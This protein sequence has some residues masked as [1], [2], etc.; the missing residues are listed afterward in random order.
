MVIHKLLEQNLNGSDLS[1]NAIFSELHHSKN[2]L[3]HIPKKEIA[4]IIKFNK[5]IIKKKE[6]GKF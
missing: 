6:K 1:F 3:I 2:K 4:K 5:R